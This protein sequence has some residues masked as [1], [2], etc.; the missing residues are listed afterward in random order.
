MTR[1]ELYDQITSLQLKDEV[2]ARF[3]KH[4]TNCSN[5][6]LESLITDVLNSMPSK[7]CK[8]EDVLFKL[9]AVLEKKRILLKSEVKE[10]LY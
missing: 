4:Y 5:A 3:G 10:I 1:K 9:I 7:P 2:K 8:V 6:Q